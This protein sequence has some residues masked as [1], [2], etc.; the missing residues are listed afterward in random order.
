[1]H[2]SLI[3]SLIK[4]VGIAI[5]ASYRTYSEKKEF[6]KLKPVAD[7]GDAEAQYKIAQFYQSGS[8]VEK[9]PTNAVE[10]FIKS[11]N[12]GLIKSQLELAKRYM[13]GRGVE[14]DY[15]KSYAYFNFS[16]MCHQDIPKSSNKKS[17]TFTKSKLYF[18][19]SDMKI[20]L[21]SKEDWV[22]LSTQKQ[23]IKLAK[24]MTPEQI[25]TAKWLA[26]K[27]KKDLDLTSDRFSLNQHM[28][29]R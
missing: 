25:Q 11:A 27:L 21:V 24:K 18:N 14:K 9:S 26:L 15:V 8:G 22:V 6:E 7:L 29:V 23:L 13:R 3:N 19:F 17:G 4:Y 28:P 1:M 5:A 2:D 20:S 10:Y 12:K 16:L